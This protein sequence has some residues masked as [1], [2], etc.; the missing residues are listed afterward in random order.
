MDKN[1]LQFQANA[2]KNL[3]ELFNYK[4][5]SE[6]K[7]FNLID[8][9]KNQILAKEYIPFY[10]ELITEKNNNVWFKQNI[11]SEYIDVLK[12]ADN[13]DLV[14]S[15]FVELYNTYL[16]YNDKKEIIGNIYSYTELSFNTEIDIDIE[17]IGFIYNPSLK[18]T[19]V[20]VDINFKPEDYNTYRD[21]LTAF[22]EYL[23]FNNTFSEK[24]KNTINLIESNKSI[25]LNQTGVQGIIPLNNF[26]FK[27]DDTNKQIELD[28]TKYYD[29]RDGEFRFEINDTNKIAENNSIFN[30]LLKLKQSVKNNFSLN[31]GSYYIDKIDKLTLLKTDYKFYALSSIKDN[32][33]KFFNSSV[34]LIFNKERTI[35]AV[36]NAYDFYYAVNLLQRF[37]IDFNFDIFYDKENESVV[38]LGNR[39]NYVK[40]PV[41]FNQATMQIEYDLKDVS[42]ILTLPTQKEYGNVVKDVWL[43]AFSTSKKIKDVIE[44]SKESGD[45]IQKIRIPSDFLNQKDIIQKEQLFKI[46][47]TEEKLNNSKLTGKDLLDKL[48]EYCEEYI[49]TY[50]QKVF[51][52]V[53]S[54]DGTMKNVFV[55]YEPNTTDKRFFIQGTQENT[56]YVWKVNEIFWRY[57]KNISIREM[58]AY[59]VAKG[60]NYNYRLL[61]YRILGVDCYLLKEKLIDQLIKEVLVC[62][63][64]FEIN[65]K[66]VSIETP[67]KITYKYEYAT[68]NYYKKRLKLRPSNVDKA[69]VYPMR[70]SIM[71]Y[72]GD[73]LGEN[74][75]QNQ[76]S[77]L[78]SEL[79]KPKEMKWNSKDESTRLL[80]HPLDPVFINEKV[81]KKNSLYKDILIKEFNKYM[82]ST[83]LVSESLT[84]DDIKYAYTLRLPEGVAIPVNFR[85]S[86]NCFKISILP[87]ESSKNTTGIDVFAVF[88]QNDVKNENPL[89]IGNDALDSQPCK[90]WIRAR[91]INGSIDQLRKRDGAYYSFSKKLNRLTPQSYENLYQGG[92][93]SEDEKN[94]QDINKENSAVIFNE[95]LISYNTK[96]SK[97]IIEGD[98]QFNR[99]MKDYVDNIDALLL[100]QKWNEKYNYLM[101]PKKID[102]VMGYGVIMKLDNSKFPIFIEHSRFFKKNLSNEFI[103]NDNQIDGIKFHVGNKNSSLLAHEV[104][105]GKTTTSICSLSHNF[106]TGNATR[107]LI[108]VPD[109]TYVNWI[110]EIK[111]QSLANGE[112]LKGLLPQINLVELGNAR[113]DVF[114]RYDAKT[115]TQ[116]GG[117][118]K[119]TR[120]QIVNIHNF[121]STTSLIISQINKVGSIYFQDYDGNKENLD[122]FLK[123]IEKTFDEKLIDWRQED[124]FNNYFS[125]IRE[126]KNNFESIFRSKLREIENEED[127]S[128]EKI[129]NST[130][131]LPK[132]K[133]DK[134]KKE[135]AKYE[136]KKNKLFYDSA[137]D[138]TNYIIYL[139]NSKLSSIFDSIGVYDECFLK[140]YTVIISTHQALSQLRV[141]SQTAN[142]VASELKDEEPKYDIQADKMIPSV[143]ARELLKNPIGFDKLNIDSI[144]VDEIHNFNELFAYSKK[145]IAQLVPSNRAE[146]LRSDYNFS[147]L[148]SL[149]RPYYTK[150]GR[151][152]ALSTVIKFNVK[153]TKTKSVKGT[154]F[155]IARKLQKNKENTNIMLLSATPFVDNLYQMIGVFNLLRNFQEP[156]EFFSNFL[157]QEWDWDNGSKGNTVLKVQTSK[158]KNGDARNNWIKMYSQFYTF[159]NNIDKQRPTKFT[160]PFDC[161]SQSNQYEDNCNTNVYL[162]FS[163]DQYKIYK[164]IGRYVDGVLPYGKIVPNVLPSTKS[165]SAISQ[166]EL[167]IIKE[168]IDPNDELYDLE[169]A[170]KIFIDNNYIDILEDTKNP[171]HK[172]ISEIYAV[173][174]DEVDKL[175]SEEDDDEDGKE[176]LTDLNDN[177]EYDGIGEETQ[178]TRAL[179]CQIDG[180]KL[181]LSPYLITE[182]DTTS[183]IDGYTPYINSDLPPLYGMNTPENLLKSAINFVETSPKIYFVVK[184]I[185]CLVRKQQE[186]NEDVT[187]QII[188]MTIGQKFWYGGLRYSGM[189]L[190]KAY[191]KNLLGFNNTFT[192]EETQISV[193]SSTKCGVSDISQGTQVSEKSKKYDLEE[194]QILSGESA[195]AVRKNAI[196]K[197]FNDGRIKILIGSKTIKEGINLQGEKNHGNS[198]I[199]VLTPD[200]APMDFMQL[201]G[202]IWR[203]GN[204]LQNVR[205]AYVL[206]KN[207][208]DVHIYSKLNEKIKKVK[209]MLEAG[210][211]DFKETQFEKD[212]EGVSLALNTN[213]DEKI[214]IEWSKE[215]KKIELQSKKYNDVLDKLKSIKENYSKANTSLDYLLLSYNAISQGLQ[216]YYVGGYARAEY[217]AKKSKITSEY[218][219]KRAELSES[220]NNK[221]KADIVEWEKLRDEND[222]LNKVNK[223]KKL[224]KVEFN[225]DKPV[226]KDNPLYTP[227]YTNLDLQ[228]EE[229]LK[230]A[231]QTVI[232]NLEQKVIDKK[233]TEDEIYYH[234]E[235]TTANSY[236]EIY[237]AVSNLLSDLTVIRIKILDNDEFRIVNSQ[238]SVTGKF[239]VLESKS[240][241]IDYAFSKVIKNNTGLDVNMARMI[242]EYKLD[243][244]GGM[245]LFKDFCKLF[246]NGGIFEIIFSDYQTFVV[247]NGETIATIDSIINDFSIKINT[248]NSKLS[249]KSEFYKQRRDYYLVEEEKIKKERESL[250]NMKQYVLVDVNKFCETNKFIYLRGKYTEEQTKEMFKIKK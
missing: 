234:N 101:Y 32:N 195:G 88:G 178:G 114:I 22:T 123:F 12:N 41:G 212:I 134:E 118:K 21:L 112:S 97:A 11:V 82:V 241:N 13:F 223:D 49:L 53:K 72:Y 189:E 197:A 206:I 91:P 63:E 225:V 217:S 228:E 179:K 214:K 95:I 38:F 180:K 183:K 236:S 20:N 170:S 172:E 230:K 211:Y 149:G 39:S 140:N 242:K 127:D 46:E 28:L 152:N 243:N 171:Y 14:C 239:F 173:I 19:I 52:T 186:N 130:K 142:D 110:N 29:N 224:P 163:D 218:T 117:I 168:Y 141:D 17:K 103:L 208:I 131:L 246:I 5:T 150:F 192:A 4:F 213:I 209:N 64:D 166:G 164:N 231:K 182:K 160:Y 219:A 94:L 233:F 220:L 237:T 229:D 2:F 116:K 135:R 45:D 65:V 129:N 125:E 159:D 89:F 235:L 153:G 136:K 120:S 47:T 249:A 75:I 33:G 158:F 90:D 226:K 222:K 104:G 37:D 145:Q 111:G 238:I 244:E 44:F 198:T 59:F 147:S 73:D 24:G 177:D 54:D 143:F 25:I 199:Y 122:Q 9:V 248:N 84:K 205:I 106:L 16:I 193:S 69:S 167:Q 99:F 50:A 146:Y 10:S 119:Y 133:S 144:I 221:F 162:D 155:G 207:S 139:I 227:D 85:K 40:V 105:F 190:I 137:K 26:L 216:D 15:K 196:S 247:A 27:S 66:T 42:F 83:N 67:L 148:D 92:F 200:Y 108:C 210:I 1:F 132:D 100:E 93:I 187:G 81:K 57:N 3:I 48:V 98:Y 113:K 86:F 18:E 124:F 55:S 8:L 71:L 102:S 174:K 74:I 121:K 80:G 77:F 87:K 35:S 240:A 30:D 138:F 62:I 6:G 61:S 245:E 128:I 79:I 36:L 109:P 184:S 126:S 78:E 215:E 58:I 250:T 51:K 107:T 157:Y 56:D 165:V 169:E 115:F 201:E 203:Q 204:P 194:V 34:N 156:I 70:E 68:G 185:E 181:A 188:Y 175:I 96:Q 60:D 151:G 154:L 43:Y 202:R 76:I 23:T 7:E 191:L 161:K 31:Y 176:E 232:E